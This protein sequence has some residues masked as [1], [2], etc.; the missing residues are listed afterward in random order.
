MADEPR[1]WVCG[2]SGNTAVFHRIP[3]KCQKGTYSVWNFLRSAIHTGKA[4]RSSDFAHESRLSSVGAQFAVAGKTRPHR[5]RRP[6]GGFFSKSYRSGSSAQSRFRR[7]GSTTL[8]GAVQDYKDSRKKSATWKKEQKRLSQLGPGAQ[9]DPIRALK[10]GLDP[11]G[12]SIT[13][14]YEFNEVLGKGYFGSVQR[15]THLETKKAYACKLLKTEQLKNKSLKSEIAILKACRH[16]NIIFLKEVFATQEYVYLVME[17]ASGGELFEWVMKKGCLTEKYAASATMQVASALA[18]MHGKGIV[19][20]DMKPENLLLENRSPRARIKVCDFG[21]SKMI[22][23]APMSTVAEEPSQGEKSVGSSSSRKAH[24][25]GSWDT[26]L[27][28]KLMS[29]EAAAKPSSGGKASARQ[30]AT[31]AMT[32][33]FDDHDVVMKSRVGTQWY[34]SPELLTYKDSYTEKIDLWGLGLIVYIMITGEHPF[35]GSDF[36]GASIAGAVTFDQP[37]RRAVARRLG[38]AA[39]APPRIHWHAAD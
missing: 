23:V 25:R 6:M 11:Q 12:P 2:R 39:R 27:D 38:R 29:Q 17:L 10:L 35:Q 31:G 3:K 7:K 34:A 19:H 28:T 26:Q 22:D 14:L 18:F 32:N 20:R 16:P 37:V 21:L 36:Y 5:C 15:V 8:T 13:E 30:D 9:D 1:V 4:L 24:R 33:R